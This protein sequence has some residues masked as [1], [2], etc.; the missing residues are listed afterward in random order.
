MDTY[1]TNTINL[2][3]LSLLYHCVT[4]I[5]S[6]V[7]VY[8][9][10]CFWNV[11]FHW[12]ICLSMC[13]YHTILIALAWYLVMWAVQIFFLLPHDCLGLILHFSWAFFYVYWP[14]ISSPSMS[15]LSGLPEMSWLLFTYWL[16]LDLS[17]LE[18]TPLICQILSFP[19]SFKKCL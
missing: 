9:S 17:V 6:Q 3:F 1:L 4:C 5:I 19:S 7:T 14:F 8:V 18:N 11:L 10:D 13:Q 2:T 12:S 15:Y 16:V